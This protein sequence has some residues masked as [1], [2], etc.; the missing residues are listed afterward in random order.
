MQAEGP[1]NLT[2]VYKEVFPFT[3]EEDLFGR[4]WSAIQAL[5]LMLPYDTR[6]SKED[7]EKWKTWDTETKEKQLIWLPL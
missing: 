2:E 3:E 7:V 4:R 5:I 1:K 6:F